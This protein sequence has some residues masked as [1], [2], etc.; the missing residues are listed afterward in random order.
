MML[1]FI[2]LETGMECN[3]NLRNYA[4]LSQNIIG[5]VL[6]VTILV[7]MG[8]WNQKMNLVHIAVI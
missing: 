8:W 7:I 5:F 1:Q 2:G 6:A 4:F 3:Y